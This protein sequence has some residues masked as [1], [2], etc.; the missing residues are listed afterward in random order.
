MKSEVNHGNNHDKYDKRHQT[1][2]VGVAP[3][4]IFCKGDIVPILSLYCNRG[5]KFFLPSLLLAFIT[6]IGHG[7]RPLFINTL[8]KFVF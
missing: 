4:T 8:Q 1:I 5:L 3:F 7:H 6:L 2:H